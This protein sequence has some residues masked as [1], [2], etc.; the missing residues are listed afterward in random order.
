[1]RGIGIL[2]LD[3]GFDLPVGTANNSAIARGVR[4]LHGEQA[5]LLIADQRQQPLQGFG[6]NQRYIAIQNQHA[7]GTQGRQGLG[8]SMPSP[9]LFG[10]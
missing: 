2:V 9:Q 7:F 6:C 5:Q 4:Q 3:D 1:M 8:H 10:L